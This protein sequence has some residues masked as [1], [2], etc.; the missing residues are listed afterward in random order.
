ML[1]DRFG[2]EMPLPE[3]LRHIAGG[4]GAGSMTDAK[5][6]TPTRRRESVVTT[7]RILTK[8]EKFYHVYTMGNFIALILIVAFSGALFAGGFY[9]GYR[10]RDNLSRERQKK[11]R[12]SQP[13]EY[14]HASAPSDSS[15]AE[16]VE[17]PTA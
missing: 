2:L 4:E 12:D 6:F 13:R 11:Y 1:L 5:H 15:S 10:H 8:C 9:M 3:V 14:F 16:T 17:S 7:T